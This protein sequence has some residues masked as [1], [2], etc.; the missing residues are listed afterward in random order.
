MFIKQLSIFI[1][2][3]KGR[4]AE[5]TDIIAKHDINIKA[6]SIAD[7]TN[8]GILRIIVDEP[9]SVE[10]I[11]SDNQITV[12]VTTVLCLAVPDKPGGIAR[13][14]SLLSDNDITVEYMYGFMSADETTAFI[15][16]RVDDEFKAQDVLK[17]NGYSG[18]NNK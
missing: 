8:F 7:T 10:N 3:R 12:S 11:L 2:N 15:V 5:I 17:A 1:E 13:V 18:Y 9:N 6:L 14:L 16:L 4:L